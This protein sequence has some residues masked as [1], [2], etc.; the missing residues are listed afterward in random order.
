MGMPSS[1]RLNL[2]VVMVQVLC[3]AIEAALALLYPMVSGT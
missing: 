3:P 1:R 2:L